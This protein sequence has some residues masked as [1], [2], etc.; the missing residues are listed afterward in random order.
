[1]RPSRTSKSAPLAGS[2]T[3]EELLMCEAAERI[4]SAHRRF[5]MKRYAVLFVGAALLAPVSAS[6]AQGSFVVQVPKPTGLCTT[7]APQAACA[8]TSWVDLRDVRSFRFVASGASLRPIRMVLMS[9][10][11]CLGERCAVITIDKTP[12]PSGGQPMYASQI[13]S[14]PKSQQQMNVSLWIAADDTSV[15]SMEGAQPIVQFYR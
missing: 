7:Q 4:C 13:I 3:E 12:S 10:G 2:Q 8:T 15:P 11:G 1:M 5:I 6:A 14:I 9:D